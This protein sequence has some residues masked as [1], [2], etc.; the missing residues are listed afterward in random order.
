MKSLVA[1]Y[2][3]ALQSR[4]LIESFLDAAH[5]APFKEDDISLSDVDDVLVDSREV[6]CSSCGKHD[7]FCTCEEEYNEVMRNGGVLR[8]TPSR[9]LN[10]YIMATS[11][12]PNEYN[13]WVRTDGVYREINGQW[14]KVTDKQ[15]LSTRSSGPR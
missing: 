9:R 5:P 10:T 11:H 15:S 4:S 1:R 2:L 7:D 14:V 8:I 13:T 6:K 12:L 3:N